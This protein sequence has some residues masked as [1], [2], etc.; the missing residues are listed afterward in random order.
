MD[1][2]TITRHDPD[3]A[4]LVAAVRG[5]GPLPAPDDEVRL[6]AV[7]AWHRLEGLLAVDPSAAA[8][9]SPD[10]V[11]H[12]ADARSATTTRWGA[13]TDRL[14]PL[15]QAWAD[16]GIAA[17]LLKGAALVR[18]GI[19][20]AGERPMADLDVLVR[21]DDVER[22]HEI[23]VGHGF[24]STTN[25]HHWAHARTRHHHLPELVHG[26]GTTV[27][28]HHRLLDV[29]H[30]QRRLDDACRERT[31]DFDA[32]GQRLDDVAMW[33]H[34]AVHCW[35]DRRRGTGGPLLQLRDLDLL[36]R[37]LDVDDLAEV[38]IRTDAITLVGSVV[39]ILDEVVATPGAADLRQR[40]GGPS[41]TDPHVAAFVER[42][43]LGRRTPLAQLVHPTGNV[44]H[45]PLRMLTRARRQ[46][47]PPMT[48]IQ[49]VEG[50]AARRREHLAS[51]WP[52]LRE[53]AGHV[54][55]TLDD[56]ALDRWAHNR[57]MVPHDR[58]GPPVG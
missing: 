24:A 27:E 45:T 13:L 34:L 11:D 53:A 12:L 3:Q 26:D 5:S 16:A 43:I 8:V 14:D 31:V 30:P 29:D 15:L 50:P 7:T 25:E 54:R 4:V 58:G 55:E 41:T 48:E 52:V 32:P 2:A 10:L 44:T 47:W 51:L 21:R 56:I 35:D 37:R 18:A 49:R 40:L 38:S 42:R 20:P 6:A 39:A 23:A 33:L 17:T 9:F 36:L 57:T 46:A 22:A 28:L 1:L 19:V